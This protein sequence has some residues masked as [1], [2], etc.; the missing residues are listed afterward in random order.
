MERGQEGEAVKNLPYW[1][2]LTDEEK[3]KITRYSIIRSYKRGQLVHGGERECL[4][5]VQVISGALRTFIISEEGR[6]VTL[7]RLQKGDSCV[8][9]AACVMETITFD[10]QMA[11]EKDTDLL[12][13]PSRIFERLTEENIYVRC[14]M[15][16]LMMER[17]SS[18]MLTM[19]E[20]LFKRFDRRLAA[21]L[22]KEYERTGKK[23]IR[24]THEQIAQHTNSAREVV[25]RM[26]KRFEADGLVGHRRGIVI[27]KDVEELQQM[28]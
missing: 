14:F 6:E 7:F 16:E 4:G 24:M 8:L 2:N 10:T 15:Y 19:Q 13:V 5:M 18:V 17:F 23:E 20:M 26:L 11:V 25:A 28:L 9:S 12:I 22:I 21:F 27:L 1:E 3:E